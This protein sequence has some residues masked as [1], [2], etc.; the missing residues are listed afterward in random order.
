MRAI[1]RFDITTNK[2]IKKRA[3]RKA[4]CFADFS[5]YS[6][7]G[8]GIMH[9]VFTVNGDEVVFLDD[10]LN[11]KWLVSECNKY[12]VGSGVTNKIYRNSIS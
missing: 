9:L 2:N 12:I 11:S 5:N 3:D 4:L 8:E 6:Y 1:T 10:R 7:I